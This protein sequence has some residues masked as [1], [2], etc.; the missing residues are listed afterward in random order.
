LVT[1]LRDGTVVSLSTPAADG[2]VTVTEFQPATGKLGYGNAFIS[3]ALAEDSLTKAGITSP[4]SAQLVTALNGGD[5]TLADG[6]VTTFSGVLALR[7]AGQGWGDI[8]KSLGVKL[9]PV[10][11]SL[12]A[13]NR[14]VENPRRP[15]I[16]GKP[17]KVAGRPDHVT[18]RPQTAGR[19]EIA[20]RPVGVGRPEGV[21][22]PMTLPAPPVPRGRP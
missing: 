3:L 5:I 19:P 2:T 18:G 17:D 20:G 12:H 11:S 7:A 21:G 16:V 13:A 15:E 22:R 9:G 8:A 14:R 10:V 1:G 4:T 6:T